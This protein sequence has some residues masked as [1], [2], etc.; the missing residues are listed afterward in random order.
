MAG[1]VVLRRLD[2]PPGAERLDVL[3]QQVG[4]ERVGM[5]VVERRA[6]LE[7]E[8]A[9]VAVVA[10]VFEDRDLVVAED[11]INRRTTV[12]LPEPDPPAIPMMTG[13]VRASLMRGS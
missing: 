4:F 8:V 5:V 13:A 2:A 3:H 10:V 11:A 1:E 7:A 9:A 6:F 12:V